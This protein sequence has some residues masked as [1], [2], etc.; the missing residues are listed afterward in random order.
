MMSRFR[1]IKSPSTGTIDIIKR[2]L[3]ASDEIVAGLDWT[4]IGLI[5]TQVADIIFASDVAEKTA[6]VDAIELSGTCPQHLTTLALFGETAAVDAAL[7]A[8]KL[9][10]SD[11]GCA[12]S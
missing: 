10:L 7:S 8:V 9:A 1:F 11:S 6:D 5:Q 4:A 2:R 3:R 12:E